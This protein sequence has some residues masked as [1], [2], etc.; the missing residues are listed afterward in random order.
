MDELQKKIQMFLIKKNQEDG[1]LKFLTARTTIENTL[2]IENLSK[3]ISEIILA[4]DFASEGT[5]LRL[6]LKCV[7]AFNYLMLNTNF[8]VQEH[9]A[10]DMVHG[11]LVDI[12]PSL[13]PFLFVQIIWKL[14][15]EDI[16]LESILHVP[17]D[18]SIEMIDIIRSCIEEL[19]FER[20][21]NIVF[22][23]I[24]N[25][26]KKFILIS[27]N[28]TQS[29]NIIESIKNLIANFQE[30]LL[31]LTNE[32]IIKM[33]E[34]FGSK[35][36]KR[37]G[38]L[39]KRIIKVVKECIECDTKETEVSEDTEKIYKITFGRE[40]I[41][42]CEDSFITEAI[43][44][45][46]QDLLSLLLKKIKEIDCNIYLEWVELDDTDNP[47]ISLQKAIGNEC[48]Y[49]VEFLKANK[50]L[51]QNE[52]LIECLQ[53]LS[54]KPISDEIDSI[55]TVQELCHGTKEG[56]KECIKELISRY[57]EWDKTI[58]NCIY[59]K[60]SSLDKDDCLN[61]LEYLTY[62]LVQTD[63]KEY[64][65]YVYSRVTQILIC[66]SLPDIL[67]ILVEYLT[68]HDGRNCLECF[69]TEEAF[70][71]FII[72]NTN[73]KSPQ[74]LKIILLFLLRNPKK[75]LSIL[76]KI[77]IGYPEYENV[78]IAP[79]DLLLL[80]PIMSIR[81]DSNETFLRST[82]KTICLENVEWNAR[83]FQNLLFALLDSSVLTMEDVVN[84][85]LLCYLKGNVTSLR[86]TYCI[87][88]CIRKMLDDTYHRPVK[89]LCTLELLV[90]LGQAMSSTRK[91]T[92]VSNYLI[93]DVLVQMISIVNHV[94]KCKAAIDDKILE[95]LEYILEPM[96]KVHFA[97]L[98]FPTRKS[99]DTDYVIQDYER[100]CFFILNTIKADQTIS[101]E[102]RT[103]LES[104][105][106][107]REDFLRHVI[108]FSTADEYKKF[109]VEFRDTFNVHYK[110]D[111][112]AYDN[113]LRIT[114]DACCL[115][116]EYPHILPRNSFTFLL[117]KLIGF[118][119]WILLF[120]GTSD[121]IFSDL[122]RS[123][124]KN[125]R[126]L[127]ESIECYPYSPLFTD[128]LVRMNNDT[129]QQI[130]SSH[131][132]ELVGMLEQFTNQCKDFDHC[133]EEH[134]SLRL[135]PSPKISRYR[136]VHEFILACMR[137]P[138]S[139]AYECITRIDHLFSSK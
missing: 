133:E 55:L 29:S 20:A 107:L 30:L 69:Y 35:K 59:E 52:H 79:Q 91:R 13:S 97:V 38:I 136:L 53:Q 65:E 63:N 76:L 56:K 130:T 60:K 82:L 26:Y 85:I 54:S 9:L 43:T 102:L 134:P 100:R 121:K 10:E 32:K 47:T 95:D 33:E 86:N 46:H 80:S 8:K 11:H 127:E 125:V 51:S 112:D 57:K 78:M 16:L 1:E 49:F 119:R 15:Y 124:I 122:Y 110:S 40:P 84:N 72:Y 129:R 105:Y 108:L 41:A 75:V 58:I 64:H 115:S 132:L 50:E 37:S 104:F 113:L 89:K 99:I 12:C 128:L 39:L 42:R 81:E 22:G 87:L 96:D 66:Q 117:R 2:K 7:S 17:L 103:F 90:S 71:D 118:L 138:A 93:D 111:S 61:L 88:N 25:V 120:Y 62:V 70:N 123:L 106:F 73:M 131:V 27:N 36:Y 139:K 23:L 101:N 68:K 48:Y 135:T 44:T 18:L 126:S 5:K 34:T 92:D 6:N 67:V 98:W 24:I 3:S 45:M 21:I 77:A 137:V 114:M 74:I 116:L 14:K 31:L 28:G 109:A 4:F 19:E 83:K 94:L